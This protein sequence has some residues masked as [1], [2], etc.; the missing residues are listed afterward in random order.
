MH[1]QGSPIHGQDTATSDMEEAFT[2]P[3]Y[4][5]AE[6]QL[7]DGEDRVSELKSPRHN[8]ETKVQRRNFKRYQGIIKGTAVKVIQ[9]PPPKSSQIHPNE[10][11]KPV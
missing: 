5:K 11:S 10:C 6:V 7:R 4:F 8:G 3:Q 9:D 1:T 2:K